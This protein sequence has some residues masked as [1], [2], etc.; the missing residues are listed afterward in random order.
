MGKG[1]LG[2]LGVRAK[3]L[4]HEGVGVFVQGVSADDRDRE[5][6]LQAVLLLQTVGPV[7][8]NRRR[9]QNHRAHKRE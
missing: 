4:V 5:A 8:K 9:L 2:R 3:Y 6:L 7:G 1:K